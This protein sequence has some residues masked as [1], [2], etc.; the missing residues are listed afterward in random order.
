LPKVCIFTSKICI[1]NIRKA[2]IILGFGIESLVL[3]PIDDEGRIICSEFKKMLEQ[4]KNDDEVNLFLNLS[5]GSNFFGTIDDIEE[6]TKIAKEH[7]MWVHVESAFILKK[8]KDFLT[9]VDSTAFFLDKLF[10]IP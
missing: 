4:R 1:N 6:C 3:L 5:L 10:P 9:K 7:K 8:S 2:A